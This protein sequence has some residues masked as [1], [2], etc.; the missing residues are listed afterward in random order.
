[1]ME[2]WARPSYL[3]LE[4]PMEPFIFSLDVRSENQQDNHS[5]K[6]RGTPVFDSI[7]RCPLRQRRSYAGLKSKNV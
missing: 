4:G 2:P 7:T 5:M 3:I 1:M 6:R